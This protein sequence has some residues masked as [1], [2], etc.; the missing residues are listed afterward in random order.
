MDMEAL[1]T[2]HSG[3]PREGPGSD[4]ATREAIRRLPPL[5]SRP[6]ILDLGCG[7]GKQTL[8]LARHFRTPIMA[9][10]FHAPYLDHLRQSAEAEGLSD[11]VSV[12]L[13]RMEELE[14]QPGSVD[15]IWIEGAIYLVGFA[16]GLRLW[17]P[18]LRNHGLLVASEATWLTGDPPG[19]A[20]V[21]WQDAYP[22][23]RTVEENL[24]TAGACGYEVL[25]HFTLPRSAWCD[26]Y[27]TPLSERVGQLRH[28]ASTNPALAEVLDDTERE[29]AIFNRY[30]DSFGYVFYLMQKTS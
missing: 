23:M 28:E 4:D 14:E 17:R 11:L 9:V 15:L 13:G 8:V 3:I 12:R 1:F 7:P 6:R 22:A 30:G 10:D 25:D 19:E 2:L 5:P 20:R 27:Y 16:E 24:K 18:I 21:F 29:I 26:E